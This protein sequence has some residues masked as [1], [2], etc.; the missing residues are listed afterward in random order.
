MGPAV[1]RLTGFRCPPVPREI[2][3]RDLSES[4]LVEKDAT[5]VNARSRAS[6]SRPW[7]GKSNRKAASW[8]ASNPS[9]IGNVRAARKCAAQ[10]EA[11]RNRG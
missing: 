8:L 6:T 3:A 10:G 1:S 9:R 5:K 11:E 4:P 2:K 7:A